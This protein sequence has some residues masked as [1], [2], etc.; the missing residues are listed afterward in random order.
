MN[1]SWN[2]LIEISMA[3]IRKIL[4]YKKIFQ[5][6]RPT[7][8]NFVGH[9]T[10]HNKTLYFLLKIPVTVTMFNVIENGI[11]YKTL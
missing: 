8:P 1:A 4:I 2:D 3:S 6:I 11:A 5:R 9:E 7:D 10:F